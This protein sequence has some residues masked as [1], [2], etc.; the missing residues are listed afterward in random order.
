MET[1]KPLAP[2]SLTLYGLDMDTVKIYDK[3]AKLLTA[4]IPLN[5]AVNNCIFIIRI[6]GITDT[7]DLQYTGYPQLLSK[8][9]GY[10]YFFNLDTTAYTTN[11]IDS[12]SVIKLNITTHN[13]EN[14]RIFY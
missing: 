12:I 7:L 3:T 13:E 11:A 1:G 4:L 5:A 14:I 10:T 9:C 6:N 8:E 2:D